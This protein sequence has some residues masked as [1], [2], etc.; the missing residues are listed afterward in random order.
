MAVIMRIVQLFEASK[1]HQFMELE[2]KFSEL[3]KNRPDYPEGERMQP[4]S[5]GEPVN[6]LIWQYRFP[7]IE[8][9]YRTLNFFNGDP[10]HEKL[11]AQQSPLIKNVKIEFYKSLDF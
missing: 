6:T 1:E 5:A 2:K 7:D 9:A 11:F 3:E 8:S 4:I 10:D